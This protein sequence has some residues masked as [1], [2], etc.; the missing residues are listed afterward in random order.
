MHA[1]A[2]PLQSTTPPSPFTRIPGQQS[3][4]ASVRSR[5]GEETTQTGEGLLSVD[6]PIDNLRT[7]IFLSSFF[8]VNRFWADDFLGGPGTTRTTPWI[9]Q[10]MVEYF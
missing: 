9:R 6:E 7:G 3:Q 4:D 8:T 2:S 1:W 5:E 10:G